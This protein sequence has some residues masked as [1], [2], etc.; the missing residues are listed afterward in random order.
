MGG[1]PGATPQ[2]RYKESAHRD[3]QKHQNAFLKTNFT[4]CLQ[5]PPDRGL[6]ATVLKRRRRHGLATSVALGDFLSLAVVEYWPATELRAFGLSSLDALLATLADELAL[7]LGKTAHHRQDQ[8]TLRTG[9]VTPRI[10]ERLE[11]SA[12]SRLDADALIK[13]G[14]TL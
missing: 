5:C 9:G 4:S 12:G 13:L 14:R 10:I 7:E 1:G 11:A 8:L 3:Q 6:A 2:S